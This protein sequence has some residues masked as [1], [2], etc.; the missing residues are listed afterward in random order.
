MEKPI[1][2]KPKTKGNNENLD[3]AII[4]NNKRKMAESIIQKW[5]LL[6]KTIKKEI[7]LE[8]V[9]TKHQ[10][11]EFVQLR[12]YFK[13]YYAKKLESRK[14]LL[15]GYDMFGNIVIHNERALEQITAAEKKIL[16]EYNQLSRLVSQL[17]NSK[18][19]KGMKIRVV[20]TLGIAYDG[21]KVRSESDFLMT[22]P[23]IVLATSKEEDA[24][25]SLIQL[26][27]K[28]TP[29]NTHIFTFTDDPLEIDQEL[30]MIGY[31]AGLILANTQKGISVQMTSGKVTQN[32]DSSRILYS[33]PTVQGSSGS[34]VLN[35]YGEVVGVNFAKLKASDNF[36]FAI[37]QS[38][39]DAIG[40]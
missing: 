28:Q 34:P 32:P 12:D 5:L 1:P 37:P 24:D 40:L 23:A 27:S 36:N 26:K 6:Q 35:K 9:I 29:V 4:E 16:E 38:R 15:Q 3:E 31:N 14:V 18:F 10:D 2:I 39:K 25:L 7:T 33:I 17:G 21:D 11:N 13:K 19:Q 20:K 8:E 30:Y 22:N